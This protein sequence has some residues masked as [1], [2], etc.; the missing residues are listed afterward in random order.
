MEQSLNESECGLLAEL[1]T[2]F[3][4]PTRLQLFCCMQEGRKSVSELAEY[5]GVT[6]QNASQHLRLMRDKGALG[7]H[8]EGQH[9]YYEVVDQR[10]IEAAQMM[11]AALVE[12]I[13]RKAGAIEPDRQTQ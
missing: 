1:F 8:K 11:R 12:S 10:F 13:Q 2:V 6:L 5:A 9:V 7:T 4:N 3:A